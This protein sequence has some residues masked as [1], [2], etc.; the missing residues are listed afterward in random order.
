MENLY[1]RKVP[2]DLF[3]QLQQHHGLSL[4]LKMRVGVLECT[5]FK[6]CVRVVYLAVTFRS[7][8]FAIF[9][10]PRSSTG[11][12]PGVASVTIARSKRLNRTVYH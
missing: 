10:P 11:Y 5:P 7:F 9:P 4:D 2:D 6:G 3:G 12:E 1:V 8:N